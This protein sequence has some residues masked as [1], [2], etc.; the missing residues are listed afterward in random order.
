MHA[1]KRRVTFRIPNA[2]HGLVTKLYE[3]ATVENV[4][5]GAEAVDVTAVVDAK[6]YGA[7]REYDTAPLPETED[8]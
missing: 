1:G 2:K 4:E 7:L 8:E 6:T 5:Y 3:N